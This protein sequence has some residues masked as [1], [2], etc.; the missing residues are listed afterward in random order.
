MLSDFVSR[1]SEILIQASGSFRSA[2]NHII[3]LFHSIPKIHVFHI[4]TA[5][6]QSPERIADSTSITNHLNFI[7]VALRVVR[8]GEREN[9]S[10]ELK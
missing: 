5:S 9:L 4:T 6:M 1:G 7:A 2:Y 10:L 3:K 8:I